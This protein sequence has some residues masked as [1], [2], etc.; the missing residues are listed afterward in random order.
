MAKKFE[1]SAFCTAC[2]ILV[3]GLLNPICMMWI[4]T[5]TVKKKLIAIQFQLKMLKRKYKKM[6]KYPQQDKMKIYYSWTCWIRVSFSPVQVKLATMIFDSRISTV[7]YMFYLVFNK[8]FIAT[9]LLLDLHILSLI[10]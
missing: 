4:I 2:D 3:T 10:H 5:K 7:S 1:S 6:V 8:A 9:A